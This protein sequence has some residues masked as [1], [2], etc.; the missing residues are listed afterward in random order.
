[1]VAAAQ[2][3]TGKQLSRPPEAY[4]RLRQIPPAELVIMIKACLSA[5]EAKAWLETA[6]LGRNE[7]LK[8]L[9]LPIATFNRKVKEKGR[10]SPAESERVLGFARLVGQLQI[11]VRDAGGPAD[12]DA[13]AWLGRWLSEP[14]PALGHAR[15]MDF[16]D[17]MEGQKLV[18]QSLAQI[19]SGAYA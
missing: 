2:R 3:S 14:L 6:T 8:A 18:S 9:D 5:V 7:T 12:F 1:M 4:N 16:M 17:T 19:G 13:K 10:L 15:P 11:I